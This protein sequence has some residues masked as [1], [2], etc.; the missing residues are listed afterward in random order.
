MPSR[1]NSIR[2]FWCRLRRVELPLGSRPLPVRPAS[3]RVQ[4]GGAR[5][6]VL[7]ALE[8]RLSPNI[9]PV[10]TLPPGPYNVVKTTLFDLQVTTTDKDSGEILTFSLTGAPTGASITSV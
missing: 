4:L 9:A 10:L 6:L 5:P 8:D 1:R 3:L 7:E 2:S